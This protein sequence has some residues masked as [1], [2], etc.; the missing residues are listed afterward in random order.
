MATALGITEYDAVTKD[1]ARASYVVPR[2]YILWINESSLLE[3]PDECPVLATSKSE[4]MSIPSGLYPEKAL[5]PHDPTGEADLTAERS[6]SDNGLSGESDLCYRGIPYA[7]IVQQL[8]IV[9]GVA[10]GAVQGERNTV[11]FSMA[12]YMRYICDFNV[13]L[14]LQVLPDFGL[15][16]QERRQVI[17]SA[18]GRPRKSQIPM[19]LQGVIAVC[20]REMSNQQ[21]WNFPSYQGC[22]GSSAVVCLP[23]TVLPWS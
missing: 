15:S 14:L 19:I 23:S 2:D 9:L 20:E 13:E 8:L 12:N 6:D 3:M 10:D 16:E 21:T 11:Y 7:D 17:T 18:I 5:P 1:L 22:C 4:S